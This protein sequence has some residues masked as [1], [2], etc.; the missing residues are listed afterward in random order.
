MAFKKEKYKNKNFK[1]HIYIFKYK[2]IIRKLLLEYKFSE[3]P[4]LYR[5]LIFFLEKYQKKILQADF[6]DIIIPV[7]IS[8][9]RIKKR[10]YNQSK[11]ITKEL[12][13]ILNIKY[14]ANILIK[15]K[16]NIQQS[17]LNKQQRKQNVK[18]VYKIKNKHKILNKNILLV[19]DIYTTGATLNECAKVL[20]ES[21][22]Q[23]IDVFT[24][25]K[26]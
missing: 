12:A 4:Y 19:D 1:N 16:N 14:E 26:D 11:L 5:S 6:Y 21:G 13:N 9:K 20:K 24:I 8:K 22:A 7:P 10:G 15:T 25:A 3:K 17:F 23:K 2:G 18:G